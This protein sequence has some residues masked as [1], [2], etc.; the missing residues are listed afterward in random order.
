[1]NLI[2]RLI[3][4]AALLIFFH[5]STAEAFNVYV[6][7]SG[8]S[9]NDTLISN[10]L[11]NAGH[12]VTIGQQYKYFD[13]SES[14]TGYEAVVLLNSY[15]W[16]SDMP[17]TGQNSILNF[18]T[19]GGGL[20][21][22]EW[23]IWSRGAW[24]LFSSLEVLSPVAATYAYLFPSPIT[25]TQVTPD[26]ILNDGVAS[27]FTFTADNISGTETYF[28]AKSGAT[29]YYSSATYSPNGLIGWDYDLGRVISFSTVIGNTEMGNVDYRNL[30]VNAVEWSAGAVIP[31]PA[32][33]LLLG[34]G[35]VGLVGLR[36]KF[37]K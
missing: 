13:G 26:P 1:M 28:V 36:K 8:N 24:G 37:K 16:G 34:S 6:M 25:Y 32:T 11:T 10:A 27:P 5:F 35:L 18:V 7:G 17:L 19:D 30:F 33:M 9:T 21:T 29:V 20:V 4:L 23:F 3:L 31:E 12:S 22:G 2:K 14:L 15:N